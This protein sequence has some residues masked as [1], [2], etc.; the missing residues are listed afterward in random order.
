MK[1]LLIVLLTVGFTSLMAC[2]KCVDVEIAKVKRDAM[3]AELTILEKNGYKD[4]KAFKEIM[5][6]YK[7]WSIK[8]RELEAKNE[9]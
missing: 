5:A 7:F 2:D 4:S 9:K 3:Y 1:K 6:E 8:L